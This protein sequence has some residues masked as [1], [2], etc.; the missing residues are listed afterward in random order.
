MWLH[1]PFRVMLFV[2]LFALWA[3]AATSQTAGVRTRTPSGVAFDEP[4]LLK[5]DNV[6]FKVPTAYLT[7]WATPD[8]V[9][10]INPKNS[11]NGLSF[12][13]W[14]PSKRPVE[15]RTEPPL[16]SPRPEE[17]GRPPAAPNEFAVL[18]NDLRFVPAGSSD[19]LTPD[20]RFS[21]LAAALEVPQDSFQEKLG[22]QQFRVLKLIYFDQYRHIPGAQPQVLLRCTPAHINLPNPNCTGHMHYDDDNLGFWLALS[23]RHLEN[24]REVASAVRD[25]AYAWRKSAEH[26]DK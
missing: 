23:S 3:N 4:I 19:Y 6:L 15:A 1:S 22:L 14:V 12:M 26:A 13:F 2:S 17:R 11:A 21:N 9:G 10:R 18:V 8:M 7:T 5:V 16:I 20:K 24:W 25:L